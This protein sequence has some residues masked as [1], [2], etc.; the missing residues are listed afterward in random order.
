MSRA[1]LQEACACRACGWALDGPG[2]LGDRPTHAI[3]DCCGAEAG[4]DDTSVE[5]TR[6]YRRTWVERGAEWFDP[7]CRPVR[8]SL[9]EHLCSI[10][11]P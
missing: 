9:Y 11:A 6:A 8:W 7:G 10:D 5:A 1:A 3:C 2:W 4:V